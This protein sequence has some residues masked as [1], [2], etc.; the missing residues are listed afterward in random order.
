MDDRDILVFDPP[1]TRYEYIEEIKTA[2]TTTMTEANI[3]VFS[4]LTSIDAPPVTVALVETSEVLVDVVVVVDAVMVDVVVADVDVLSA[5][6][7]PNRGPSLA[8]LCDGAVDVVVSNQKGVTVSKAAVSHPESA[9]LV[10][11]TVTL[12]ASVVSVPTIPL[13]IQPP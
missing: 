4:T 9:I 12:A 5:R 6:G 2:S 13:V 1:K 7:N 8:E 3:A 11:V 10:G